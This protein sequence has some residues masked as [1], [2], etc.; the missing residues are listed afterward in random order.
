MKLIIAI[1]IVLVG[2]GGF[3]AYQTIFANNKQQIVNNTQSEQNNTKKQNDDYLTKG[4]DKDDIVESN[5]VAILQVRKLEEKLLELTKQLNNNQ[6]NS[7]TE[8]F[9]IN[10]HNIN[11]ANNKIK[12]T[13]NK[14]VEKIIS[15]GEKITSQINNTLNYNINN[16]DQNYPDL[17]ANNNV[18][19][20]IWQNS[21]VSNSQSQTSY[22]ANEVSDNAKPINN[23]QQEVIPRF[24]ITQNSVFNT[25]NITALLGRIPVDGNVHNPYRFI[26]KIKDI[27][28][29]A[30]NHKNNKFNG[31][32][33]S[34]QATGDLLKSCV[35]ASIDS[36]TYIF[37][38]GTISQNNQA[39]MAF[40][41]D[42]YG[43]PC[44][45]GKLV[46]NAPQYIA[47]SSILAGVSGFAQAVADIQKTNTTS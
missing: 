1:F 14:S 30:N 2:V 45:K 44:I 20:Y 24:T 19:N 32:V 23:K 29:F 37:S 5:K 6:N 18:N 3:T 46:T 11:N 9:A 13:V 4:S 8:T 31:V 12:S 28:L 43:E 25:K 34:G 33:V 26:L 15:T 38:D 35:R 22:V 10:T 40:I 16:N 39:D 17:S 41:A 42:K 47:T 27:G 7:T 36:L 21:I